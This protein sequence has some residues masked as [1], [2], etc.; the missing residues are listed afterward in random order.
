[1]HLIP[2]QRL[3][4]AGVPED[5]IWDPRVW[6]WGC[7]GHHHAF[8]HGFVRLEELDYPD[9]VRDYAAEHGFAWFGVRDGWRKV[10]E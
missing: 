10:E 1:M 7:R 2:K 3:R 8:D 6:R 5:A 9:S 4:D